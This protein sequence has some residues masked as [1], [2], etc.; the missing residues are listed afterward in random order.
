VIP[1]VPELP[2]VPE[3][4]VPPPAIELKS[5]STV[6]PSAAVKVIIFVPLSK[7]AL[8]NSAPVPPP[9]PEIFLQRV[10]GVPSTV[11]VSAKLPPLLS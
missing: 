5:T 1:L 9:L 7:V 3:V 6:L 8:T 11:I 4:P 10:I 2:D